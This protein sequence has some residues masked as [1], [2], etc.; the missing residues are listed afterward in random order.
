MFE[1]Y[2]FRARQWAI[3]QTTA[4]EQ[5]ERAKKAGK[6]KIPLFPACSD[7]SIA[8]FISGT[9]FYKSRSMINALLD[10]HRDNLQEP[11]TMENYIRKHKS[12]A[13]GSAEN[14]PAMERRY[15]M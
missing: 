6:R 11:F 14:L 8:I 9:T 10:I 3:G 4:V 13:T 2:L 12:T 7:F 1:D 15:D 5:N